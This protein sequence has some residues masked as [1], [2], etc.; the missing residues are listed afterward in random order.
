MDSKAHQVSS[1]ILSKV[2]EVPDNHSASK[3]DLASLDCQESA[4]EE[5]KETAS[6]TSTAVVEIEESDTRQVIYMDD[7]KD[8]I[9]FVR[10]H[11]ILYY[12]YTGCVNLHL[13][14][15][16][17]ISLLESGRSLTPKRGGGQDDVVSLPRGG[18][19][20]FR[21]RGSRCI[22]S[23]ANTRHASPPLAR[24][25]RLWVSGVVRNGSLSECR[26]SGAGQ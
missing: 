25:G 20:A 21:D 10:L 16:G 22:R 1:E 8:K 4:M 14:D 13:G 24:S 9:D 17:P 2:R 26:P 18:S 11:N 23:I 12:L 19:K 5:Y 15:H 7:P 6:G 3:P